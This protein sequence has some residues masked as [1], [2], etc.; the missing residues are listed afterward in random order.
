MFVKIPLRICVEA[1]QMV[2]LS[3]LLPKFNKGWICCTSSTKCLY[4]QTFNF[5]S[6]C[7]KLKHS[8]VLIKYP[9]KT[10]YDC[11]VLSI[12]NLAHSSRQ[13]CLRRSKIIVASSIFFKENFHQVGNI[14]ISTK[15][16]TPSS[17]L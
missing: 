11:R 3:S 17:G 13:E 1:V 12:Y 16:K 7:S 9:L 5:I 10:S 6:S 4:I 2:S 8:F 14:S 15:M